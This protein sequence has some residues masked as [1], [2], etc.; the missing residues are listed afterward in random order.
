MAKKKKA[1]LKKKSGGR[2]VFLFLLLVVLL[3]ICGAV[4]LFVPPVHD[5]VSDLLNPNASSVQ[6]SSSD[7][8]TS[9]QGGSSSESSKV[10]ATLSVTEDEFSMHFIEAGNYQAGDCTYIRAGDLDILIDAGSC[11]NSATTIE[12]YID[13]YCTDGKL[14]YVIV[15][16]DHE[17]HV[18]GFYGNSDKSAKNFK[19]ETVGRT[20]IFYYYDIGTIIDFSLTNKTSTGSTTVYGKYLA[21]RQYA[22]DNGAV[23]YTADQCRNQSDGADYLYSLTPSIRMTILDSRYYY[24]TSD[25]TEN[26]YSVCTLF[27]QATADGERNYL[28]TGDLEAEGEEALVQMNDLPQVELFKGGHHGSPTSSN[29][30]LLNVIQPKHCVV[31][32]CAGSD[33]YTT[34]VDN[35]FPSQAFIDRI[36][37]WTEQVYVT[38]LAINDETGHTVGYASQNGNVVA[39]GTTDSFEI[40]GSANS[41]LLKDSEWFNRE[42]TV[43]LV[44]ELAVICDASEE[45]AFQR[46]MRTWPS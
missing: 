29:D 37:K 21:A 35:Q 44:K 7:V 36:A 19:G 26:N 32:C 4:Y 18:S 15:T 43:K 14:E 40:R 41:T 38:T 13:Q 17:D 25:D 22:M 20:G 42:I 2:P 6:P 23:H 1:P 24:E 11:G 9:S 31:C 33:E 39:K 30:C 45:G 16:H 12:S 3:I 46:P 8:N 10:S 28:M 5:F 34:N 27:T